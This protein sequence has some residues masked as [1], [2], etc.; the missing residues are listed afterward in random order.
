MFFSANSWA[1]R[2]AD[3]ILPAYTPA[4]WMWH[5][6]HGLLVRGVTRGNGRVGDDVTH[7]IRTVSNVPLRLLGALQTIATLTASP[8]RRAVLREA[9]EWIAES[10]ARTIESPHDRARFESRL[11]CVREALETEPVLLAGVKGENRHPLKPPASESLEE[12]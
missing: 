10:A 3:S 2:M 11:A 1:V 5:Y 12:K 4:Q 7:A 6:E 9:M 8:G